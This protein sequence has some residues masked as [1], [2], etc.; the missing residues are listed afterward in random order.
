MENVTEGKLSFDYATETATFEKTFAVLHASIGDRAFGIP[1]ARKPGNIA[2]GFSVY[3]FEA[4]TIG[5]QPHLHKFD[6]TNAAQMQALG[7]QL[8]KIKVDQ[9]FKEITTG[10]GKNSPGPLKTRINFVE[11]ALA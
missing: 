9:A 2:R 3:H 5:L 6:P 10:G 4:I 1:S 11:E 8:R 7:E